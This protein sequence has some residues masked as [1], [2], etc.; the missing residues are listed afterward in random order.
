[1][2]L[3]NKNPVQRLKKISGIKAHP[4]L[5]DFSWNN[6]FSM[7]MQPTYKPK[8]KIKDDEYQKIPFVTF[9]KVFI[10]KIKLK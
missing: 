6:L 4:W 7:E 8:I 5:E 10:N 9:L 3:L 1:M 2:L